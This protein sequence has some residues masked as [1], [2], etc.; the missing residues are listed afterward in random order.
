MASALAVA[1]A[2]IAMDEDTAT[3]A[4]YLRCQAEKIGERYGPYSSL[5]RPKRASIC[6]RSS[7]PSLREEEESVSSMSWQSKETMSLKLRGREGEHEREILGSFIHRKRRSRKDF[8]LL[9][10]HST[11]SFV[12]FSDC[13]KLNDHGYVLDG[14]RSPRNF[15]QELGNNTGREDRSRGLFKIRERKLTR[16]SISGVESSVWDNS[17]A[18]I[19]S[20]TVSDESELRNDLAL[21]GSPGIDAVSNT[22]LL[23]K[24]KEEPLGEVPLEMKSEG[25]CPMDL[26][27]AAIQVVS[28]GIF[29]LED[30]MPEL[31]D[32][33]PGPPEISGSLIEASND[34]NSLP[35][36]LRFVHGRSP[37]LRKRVVRRARSAFN[38]QHDGNFLQP[39]FRGLAISEVEEPELPF[40]TRK[41]KIYSYEMHQDPELRPRHKGRDQE[42]DSSN[43]A[44]VTQIKDS[45]PVIPSKRGR[46]HVLP[47]RYSDSVL[48]W[49][50]STRGKK[51][52]V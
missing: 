39:H 52:K 15:S 11:T 17:E 38:K 10:S 7:P 43:V 26:L 23:H 48:Q 22:R 21:L 28:G 32:G 29:E 41:R 50:R 47:A 44:D 5:P 4:S 34:A 51:S 3:L 1:E 37:I 45:V 31:E 8:S 18:E 14:L 49:K 27:M 6:S 19:A 20:R 33:M 36:E 12:G 9:R 46:F 2:S 16:T 35:S 13:K 24:R 30:G 25:F 40:F 42:T